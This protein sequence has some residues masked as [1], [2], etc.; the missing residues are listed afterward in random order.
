MLPP[1][2][3]HILL[4]LLRPPGGYEL[5]RAVG[6]TFTLDLETALVLPL[7]FASFRLARTKDPIALMEAVRSSASRVDVFCQAGQMTVPKTANG[8]FAF[9][10][11]MVH[12]ARRPSPGHLFH[13]KVWYLRYVAQDNA[14]KVRLLVLTRNLTD[15]GSWDIGL[16][17]DGEEDGAPKARN[18]PLAELLRAL[19]RLAV[20]DPDADRTRGIIALAESARRVTWELPENVTEQ[21]D[22]WV[23]G[24]PG[25]SPRPDFSGYRQLVV[26]PFLNEGGLNVVI[27][28]PRSRVTVVSR[29]EDLDRLP[30]AAIADLAD[31]R[32]VS[33]AADLDDPDADGADRVDRERLVGLHAKLYVTERNRR[34]YLFVGSANATDA[35]FGGNI[36][37]LVEL[38]GGATKLGVDQLLN[39]ETGFGVILE[40]YTPKGDV[41]PDPEEEAAWTLRQA[42][43]SLAE[44]PWT[45][46]VR[47]DG[48]RYHERIEAGRITLPAGVTA[49]VGLLTLPG[50]AFALAAGRAVKDQLGPVALDEVTPFIVVTA[51]I[52]FQRGKTLRRSSVIRCRLVNGP[53]GRLDEVL[54]KQVD[55][56]EKFLHFLLLLLGLTDVQIAVGEQENGAQPG[57]AWSFGRGGNGVFELLARAI[58]DRPEALDTLQTL[59]PRLRASNK[60]KQALPRGFDELWAVIEAAGPA[61]RALQ[62]HVA[63]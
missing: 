28:A 31:T 49:T 11:P 4:D 53:A 35:A 26:A 10:E 46:T 29:V 32:I 23:F 44:R 20:D 40:E 43:Q 7:A 62:K 42:L 30:K 59:I 58:A 18:R 6:T 48:D 3:R 9:L 36:E 8:L 13:P 41:A 33:A 25:P 47:A 52:R 56:P 27:P 37:I 21:P 63:S 14:P 22:F 39:N 57:G 45:A 2:H 12:E 55:T 60:G 16:R 51:S 17:L 1:D 54:A 24:L 61:L 19:P 5:D 50:S 38:T 15:D 34:A